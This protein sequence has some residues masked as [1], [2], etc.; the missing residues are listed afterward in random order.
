MNLDAVNKVREICNRI[1]TLEY[2]ISAL[3]NITKHR[4][5]KD[6]VVISLRNEHAQSTLLFPVPI[7]DINIVDNQIAHYKAEKDKIFEELEQL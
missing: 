4:K 7:T 5:E 2:H 6:D 1:K 3:K